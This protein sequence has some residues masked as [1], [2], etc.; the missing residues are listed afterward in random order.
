[1]LNLGV[2]GPVTP[3]N[4]PAPLFICPAW[5]PRARA[6]FPRGEGSRPGTPV[7]TEGRVGEGREGGR[8]AGPAGS[9][10]PPPAG[11]AAFLGGRRSDVDPGAAGSA[12]GPRPGGFLNPPPQP[13]PH[14]P[15]H[16]SAPGG[17][18]RERD[19]A[20]PRSRGGPPESRQPGAR[21]KVQS[22][23]AHSRGSRPGQRPPSPSP[24]GPQPPPQPAPA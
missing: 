15:E 10:R 20:W 22:R 21:E 5:R 4:F 16:R 23:G 3:P 14:F 6:S 9:A 8:E 1:M 7:W 24:A 17:R 12:G 11:R 18:E 13:G 19:R 2:L